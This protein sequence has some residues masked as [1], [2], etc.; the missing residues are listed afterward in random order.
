MMPKGHTSP[1]LAE[2]GSNGLAGGGNRS[3]FPIKW[4]LELL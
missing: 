2:F 1:D 3:L 4:D